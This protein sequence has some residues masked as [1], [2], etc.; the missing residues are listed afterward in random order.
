MKYV[1][2][3]WDRAGHISLDK[4]LGNNLHLGRC[5]WAEICMCLNL[6]G[7]CL[8]H[9]QIQSL[10]WSANVH[11]SPISIILERLWWNA[12]YSRNSSTDFIRGCSVFL[13]LFRKKQA[14][15]LIKGDLYYIYKH[16][17]D[18]HQ[19][20]Q[21]R[22]GALQEKGFPSKFHFVQIINIIFCKTTIG[23]R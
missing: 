13:N 20:T 2:Q 3:V 18:L 11:L 4:M 12:S 16:R 10:S 22:Q 5:K 7:L 6:W 21:F 23:E 9:G 15:E 1:D 17:S 19:C 8:N 14:R